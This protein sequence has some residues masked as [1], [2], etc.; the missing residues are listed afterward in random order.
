MQFY[1][2]KPTYENLL[3]SYKENTIDRNK[4]ILVFAKRLNKIDS[5]CSISLEGNW[6][7]GKTF[8]VKQVKM[9]L[10]AYNDFVKSMPDEKKEE[11][12][13]QTRAIRKK[14]VDFEPQVCVYYDAWE[15]DND[16]DPVLSL[17]YT[18]INSIDTDYSLTN[19]T[20]ILKTVASIAEFFTGKKWSN[21]LESIRGKNLLD[22]IRKAK[23]VEKN[24]NDF[25][26]S[27]IKERGN[28][29][30]IFIDE[31][32]RC[33]PSYAVTLLERIKH[34]F[35]N[36]RITF[37]FSINSKELQHTIKQYYGYGFDACRYLDRF[38]DSRYQLPPANLQ[39]FYN[40]INFNNGAYYF[41]NV[42]D[43]VI[44][45]YDYSLREISRY[46]NMTKM[47]AYRPTHQNVYKGF[48]RDEEILFELIYLLP[49]MIGLKLYDTSLYESFISGKDCSPL[50]DVC[51]KLKNHNF[52]DLLSENETF[53]EN[54]T[55]K[56][57]VT[58]EEK[59]EQVYKALFTNGNLSDNE[60]ISVGKYCFSAYTKE[61]LQDAMTLLSDYSSI[62]FDQN[63]S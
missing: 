46:I 38:F 23:S 12:K 13:K 33:K 36:D 19:D 37:V 59:L 53:N 61:Q 22:E 49:I 45:T 18:I 43:A 2:L 26:D 62:D 47:A 15:N 50:I 21:L 10:D 44:K 51:K 17:I 48:Y 3:T 34:Y 42:C 58:L 29:L 1:D 20:D 9:I 40:S 57:F 31:L 55:D 52:R 39:Y 56:T 32:D 8:F 41:D 24:I 30:V 11:I 63:Q 35:S 27:I 7:S 28:R 4:H 6:G 54:E 25:L 14:E 5:S 16:S 60:C